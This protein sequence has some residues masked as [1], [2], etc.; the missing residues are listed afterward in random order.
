[1]GSRSGGA[2]RAGRA[3]ASPYD[4]TREELTRQINDNPWE[5]FTLETMPRYSL[6]RTEELYRSGLIGQEA[7]EVY[8]YGWRNFTPR[9]SHLYSQDEDPN[10][11]P[12]DL[13]G[14]FLRFNQRRW[15]RMVRDQ[16]N[17]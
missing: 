15:E 7:F 16:E 10:F 8:V 1:M 2:S 14:S 5:S 3:V 12:N 4:I 9:T 17:Q 11:D 6:E 13:L